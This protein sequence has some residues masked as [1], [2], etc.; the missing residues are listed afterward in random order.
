MAFM[1]SSTASC[2]RRTALWWKPLF[3]EYSA[4]SIRSFAFSRYDWTNLILLSSLF[5]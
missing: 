4:M 1:H 2:A 5:N 3:F